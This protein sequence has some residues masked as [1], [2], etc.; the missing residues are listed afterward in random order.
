VGKQIKE[1]IDYF[2]GGEMDRA[3]AIHRHLL[4]LVD[5]MFVVANPIPVK[6]ALNCIGFR[7]GKPRLPLTEPD[8]KTAAYIKDT[9]KNYQIDLPV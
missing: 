7:A 5:A 9:L 2:I 6:Y 4:P 8:E 1:M 3:A